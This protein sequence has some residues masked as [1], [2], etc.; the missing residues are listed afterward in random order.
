[1][2]A[3][4]SAAH[5]GTL[6]LSNGDPLTKEDAKGNDEADKGAKDEQEKLSAV[7]SLH[8]RSEGIPTIHAKCTKLHLQK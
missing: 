5:V 2:P 7:A 4:E 8:A 1:M 3:H 6:Q